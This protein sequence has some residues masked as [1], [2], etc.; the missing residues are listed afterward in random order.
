MPTALPKMSGA[1]SLQPLM[2]WMRPPEY[3][4]LNQQLAE[5]LQIPYIPDLDEALAR[6]DGR[7][8][9]LMCPKT[10]GEGA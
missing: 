7:Y 1:N 5:D 8:R 3:V 10:S 2:N 9:Q 6:D 4:K